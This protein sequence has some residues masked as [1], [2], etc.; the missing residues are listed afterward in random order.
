MARHKRRSADTLREVEGLL[1]AHLQDE[2][3]DGRPLA[4]LAAA[5]A[6]EHSEADRGVLLIDDGTGLKPDLAIQ[7]DLTE[8]L[9]PIGAEGL[10]LIRSACESQE[11]RRQGGRLAAPALTGSLVTC[12]LYLER[13]QAEFDSNAEELAAR[14]ATRIGA[15]L[16]SAT[17]VEELRRRSQRLST[18]EDLG[19]CLATG[20]IERSHLESTVEG[21]RQATASEGALLSL[22]DPPDPD[23]S[24]TACGGDAAARLVYSEPAWAESLEEG[25]LDAPE[26]EAVGPCLVEALRADLFATP[27]STPGL[28][29]LIAVCREEGDVPYDDNDRTF[30][31]AVAHLVS[32][33]LAR[34]EYFSQASADPLTETGSRL[35]L[36]LGLAEAQA[37]TV[38]TGRSFSILLIDIDDFKQINDCHGHP[39]GDEV[40]RGLAQTLRSRLRSTDSV[41]RY[42]GDEFVV[43]LPRTDGTQAASLAERLRRLVE[44]T[45]LTAED[46]QVHVSIGVAT[47]TA[48]DDRATLIQRA[49]KALYCS[50]ERG[51]NAVTRFEDL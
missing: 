44:E 3:I 34:A 35:S 14:V 17:L 51:K 39:V 28:L 21:A 27:G 2:S 9:E 46:L 8:S 48:G 11:V 23:L 13:D 19:V 5:L 31:R 30:L 20:Q 33:A 6:V 36:R 24:R 42:G 15:L 25:R 47:S 4:N 22:L 26:S 29:G 49:D 18:L 1:Q 7:S 37:Q 32:G 40:L 45:P 10:E 50:K 41:A 12:T 43:I 16:R 38:R